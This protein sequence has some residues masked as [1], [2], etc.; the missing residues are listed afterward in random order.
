MVAMLAVWRIHA[1]GLGL[2]VAIALVLA[3]MILILP[4]LSYWQAFRR[5]AAKGVR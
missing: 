1:S 4:C 3:A 2:A 5:Q